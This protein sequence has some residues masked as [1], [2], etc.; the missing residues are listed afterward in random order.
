MDHM[1][2]TCTQTYATALE[3]AFKRSSSSLAEEFTELQIPTEGN[4][5]LQEPLLVRPFCSL[6]INKC[7]ERVV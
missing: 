5:F 3:L 7:V 2:R 4:C 1:M 6:M